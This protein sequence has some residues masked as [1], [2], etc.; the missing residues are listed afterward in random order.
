[1]R[2]SDLKNLHVTE[3]VKM[4]IE[5]EIDGANRMRKQDLIFALLKNQARKGENIYGH[6]T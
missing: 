3:L 6:G 2:L 1:M 5:N 4:A